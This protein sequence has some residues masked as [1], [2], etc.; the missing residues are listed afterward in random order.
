MEEFVEEDY[1]EYVWLELD[2]R[3]YA[4]VGAYAEHRGLSIEEVFK[5]VMR[6][7]IEDWVENYND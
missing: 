2:E 1:K 7:K 6:S 4:M 5:E 3:D